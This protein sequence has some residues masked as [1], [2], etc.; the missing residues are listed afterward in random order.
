MKSNKTKWNKVKGAYKVI[1]ATIYTW[2]YKIH[3]NSASVQCD[4]IQGPSY[5]LSCNRKLND[6]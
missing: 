6:K 1:I 3:S 5:T 4:N 2:A